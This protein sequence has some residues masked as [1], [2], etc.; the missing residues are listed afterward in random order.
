MA[1]NKDDEI[2]REHLPAV[3]DALNNQLSIT[4]DTMVHSDL[5]NEQLKP[6]KMLLMASKSLLHGA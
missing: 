5:M 4:I 3:L 1:L 6:L 2:T